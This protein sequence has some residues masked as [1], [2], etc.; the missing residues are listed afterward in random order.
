MGTP[1]VAPEKKPNAGQKKVK[2]QYSMY[3]NQGRYQSNRKRRLQRHLK[4]HP[5]DA[6]AKDAV[7]KIKYRRKAPNQRVWSSGTIEFAHTLRVLG[8]NGADIRRLV[9]NRPVA[10]IHVSTESE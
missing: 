1:A 8:Y 3:A 7:G 9:F 10:A 5:T 6:V 4:S 2:G